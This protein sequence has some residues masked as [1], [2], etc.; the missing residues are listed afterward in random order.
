[1][2]SDS[3]LHEHNESST[4][5]NLSDNDYQIINNNYSNIEYKLY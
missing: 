3:S 5:K 1:M 2:G 4:A